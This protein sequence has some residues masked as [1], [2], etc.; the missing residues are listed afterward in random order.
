LKTN[1]ILWTEAEDELRLRPVEGEQGDET[2]MSESDVTSGR[3]DEPSR[4][5]GSSRLQDA[6]TSDEFSFGLSQ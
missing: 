2:V 3:F 5:E 4:E 6:D 1:R